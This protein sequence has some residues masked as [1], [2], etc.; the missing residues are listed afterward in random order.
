MQRAAIHRKH[1]GREY[2]CVTAGKLQAKKDLI[3][4]RDIDMSAE[5]VF[6]CMENLTTS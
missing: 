5:A 6:G 1:D 2:A 4:N 3:S